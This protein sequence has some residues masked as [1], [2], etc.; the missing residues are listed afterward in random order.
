[1]DLVREVLLI[2]LACVLVAAASIGALV[3]AAVVG[4]ILTLDGLLLASVC[5]LLAATFGGLGAWLA[6]DAG[7]LNRMK[8]RKAENKKASE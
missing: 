3:W 7:L 8:A 4:P 5:L 2:V 6:C 1:M